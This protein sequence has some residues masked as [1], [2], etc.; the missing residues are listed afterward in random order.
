M[1]KLL[2]LLCFVLLAGGITFAD[3][4]GEMS[5]EFYKGTGEEDPYEYTPIIDISTPLSVINEEG[6][7]CYDSKA[8]LR[9]II[10]ERTS[11]YHFEI[12]FANPKDEDYD[13]KVLL[14]AEEGWDRTVKVFF[15]QDIFIKAHGR[16]R[17]KFTVSYEDIKEFDNPQMHGMYFYYYDKSQAGIR[18]EYLEGWV[19][20]GNKK[21]NFDFYV[22]AENYIR[23]QNELNR[24][25]ENT[26]EDFRK[27]NELKHIQETS[28]VTPYDYGDYTDD[29][30]IKRKLYYNPSLFPH[31][32]QTKLVETKPVYHFDMPWEDDDDLM[33]DYVII[34][35]TKLPKIA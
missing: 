17:V 9:Y 22:G 10:F 13:G 28:S 8:K 27:K 19:R 20:P 15:E 12:E 16:K 11:Q 7:Q 30:G 6:D 5:S 35:V 21:S 29:N 32:H 14:L 31:Y 18:G 3:D 4:I 23:D 2:V 1:K 24:L 25:I 33:V 34:S 26:K